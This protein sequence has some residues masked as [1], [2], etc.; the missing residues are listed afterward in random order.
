MMVLIVRVFL[1][2]GEETDWT[3]RDS[4]CTN[5]NSVEKVPQIPSFES[6]SRLHEV[7]ITGETMPNEE[8]LVEAQIAWD[9]G[10]VLG[11]RV[12]NEKVMIDAISKVRE[13][14]ILPYRKGGVALGRIR[15]S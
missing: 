7:N 4:E 15:A 6:E 11:L 13:F 1:T 12:S 10:K 3:R 2:K 14:R 5:Y 8:D 9:I